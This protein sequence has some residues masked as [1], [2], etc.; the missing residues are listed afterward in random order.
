MKLFTCCFSPLLLS[1]LLTHSPLPL[2]HLI[3]V[4]IRKHQKLRFV[5]LYCCFFS[6]FL[7][8]DLGSGDLF[9]SPLIDHPLFAPLVGS[10]SPSGLSPAASGCR[11]PS[12]SDNPPPGGRSEQIQNYYRN[13]I[14]CRKIQ[15]SRE[16]G[17]LEIMHA[18]LSTGSATPVVR[19]G[20][21]S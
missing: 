11:Q 3:T 13:P 8:L 12:S 5:F 19:G 18:N 1:L 10:A 15:R 7:L 4:A 16:F 2:P 9:F 17:L 14:H 6:I 20:A 21:V